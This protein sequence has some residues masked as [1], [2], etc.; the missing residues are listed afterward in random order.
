MGGIATV[1]A[2]APQCNGGY[3]ID[4]VL[5]EVAIIKKKGRTRTVDGAEYRYG[6][7][8]SS[9]STVSSASESSADSTSGDVNPKKLLILAT[10]SSSA[11]SLSKALIKEGQRGECV[12][13]VKELTEEIRKAAGLKQTNTQ[14]LFD[15]ANEVKRLE[16]ELD[17]A[18]CNVCQM[19]QNCDKNVSN[20]RLRAK[21]SMNS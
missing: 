1:I 21:K 17:K 8:T 16:V 13:N 3:G 4:D 10:S 19:Q 12:P 11:V 20:L 9:E 15:D 14:G 5:G 2:K 7:V 18:G 6:L